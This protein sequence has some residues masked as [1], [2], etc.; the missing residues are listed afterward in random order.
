VS[1]YPLGLRLLRITARVH[2]IVRATT[3]YRDVLG[4]EVGEYGTALDGAMKYAHMHMP[5]YGL[6][7]VQ[8]DRPALDVG[9]GQPVLPSWIHPVFAV[10]D[11]DGLYLHMQQMGVKVV[12]RG[13]GVP[14][15]VTTFLFYD[16]EGNELEVVPEATV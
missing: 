8:L 7:L 5:S 6:S 16:S 12:V 15:K 3:W 9:A 10:A 13:P 11:P 1:A 14:A 2:D 4:F